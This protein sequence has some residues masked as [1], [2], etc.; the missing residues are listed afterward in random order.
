MSETIRRKF[1]GSRLWR[2]LEDVENS[3]PTGALTTSTATT[4]ALGWMARTSRYSSSY[5]PLLH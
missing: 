4:T 1:L 5:L 2:Q 3:A